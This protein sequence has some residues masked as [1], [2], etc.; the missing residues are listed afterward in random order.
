MGGGARWIKSRRDRKN[1]IRACAE[2]S[3][4][5]V[6]GASVLPLTVP[7]RNGQLAKKDTHSGPAGEEEEG[8]EEV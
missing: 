7:R 3:S 5:H 4:L 6:D 8:K 1:A 2:L